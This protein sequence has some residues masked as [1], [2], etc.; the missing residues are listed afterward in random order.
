MSSPL[1]K[2]WAELG[3]PD[4]EETRVDVRPGPE[5]FAAQ[6]VGLQ[7]RILGPGKL[8]AYEEERIELRDLVAVTSHPLW[9]GGLR[10]RSLR[11]IAA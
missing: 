1:T 9:G 4:L 5:W 6:P 2:T 10:E 8:R 3:F 11:E 7:R